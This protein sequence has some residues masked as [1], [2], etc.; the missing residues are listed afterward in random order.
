MRMILLATVVLGLTAS[1]VPAAAPAPEWV[2]FTSVTM[3]PTP[4]A[5]KKA[6]ARGIELKQEPGTPLRGLLVLPDGA[7][8][9][10]AV[11]L[12]H[13]CDGVQPFQER[14]AA[15]LA[16]WSY[17]ALLA[18]S[19]APRGIGDDCAHWPPTT[20]SR[21]FD[22]FDAF[23]ALRYLS[24]LTFVDAGRVGVVGWDTGGRAVQR[25]LEAKGVQQAV[26]ERFAA[27]VELYPIG[28]PD[29]PV[30]APVLLLVGD[31]DDC[32]PAA[33]IR[34]AM[35]AFDPGPVPLLLDVLPDAGHSFDNPHFAEPIDF[36][37]A[38]MQ[39]C[40]ETSTTMRY[41]KT[42]HEVAMERVHAFLEKHLK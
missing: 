7:G 3:P 34:H 24:G 41:S 4:F 23:G 38:Q 8:P 27:G 2:E 29:G 13:G 5:L 37:Y 31:K 17:V 26:A 28:R 9:F 40:F 1:S 33:R 32:S 15:D 42:A 11:V 18:D 21:P 6:K 12:L 36:T 20:D 39:Q 14:W 25:A 16:E 22:A 19:H 30:S 35:A 10:P